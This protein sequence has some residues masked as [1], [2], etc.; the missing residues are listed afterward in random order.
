MKKF[1][2]NLLMLLVLA[3]QIATATTAQAGG[4]RY[5]TRV[6]FGGGTVGPKITSAPP[7]LAVGTP[8]TYRPTIVGGMSPYICSA[9]TLPTGLMFSVSTCTVAGTP[10]VASPFNITVADKS[11]ASTA[12]ALG[13]PVAPQYPQFAV[14]SKIA[15]LGDSLSAAGVEGAAPG[16]Q[17]ARTTN[18]GGLELALLMNPVALAEQWPADTSTEDSGYIAEYTHGANRAVGGT[19]ATFHAARLSTVLA[20]Q[21]AILY[22]SATVNSLT[23]SDVEN[24][25]IASILTPA[26]NAG[27][28]LAVGGIRPFAQGST[29]DQGATSI[30]ARIRINNALKAWVT[31]Q[32]PS[33]AI[34]VDH[35][36]YAD[37]D[38]DGYGDASLYWDGTHWNGLGSSMEGNYL[39]WTIFPQIF[40]SGNRLNA[41]WAAANY[42]SNP[43]LTGTGGTRSGNVTYAS[44]LSVPN[45]W[46]VGPSGTMTS[47]A[48]AGLEANA[49]T[50][51]QNIVLTVTP[52]A[53]PTGVVT[54]S[55]SG[56][57]LSVTATTSGA[58]AVGQKVT[59]AS[60]AADTYITAGAGSAFTVN[61]SQ[62]VASTSVS[63]YPTR[64]AIQITPNSAGTT[65]FVATTAL[66][67][68]YVAAFAEIEFDGNG[69]WIAPQLILSDNST[70]AN[71][72]SGQSYVTETF[73]RF[74]YDPT[75]RRMYV[76][77]NALLMGASSDGFRYNLTV[78]F[79]P[80]ILSAG[81]VA[82]V[83]RTW[84]G[85]VGNPIP[86]WGNQP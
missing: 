31:A 16:T 30:A 38:H 22:Y 72:R 63:G 32:G 1:L 25:I 70:T 66:Q 51:G 17:V 35:D 3:A 27:V 68:Q 71:G 40:A 10:T 73:G 15:V 82:K 28:Y 21:P 58:L 86:R 45:N 23:A 26:K 29:F 52:N 55:I 79:N 78:S 19:P 61:K 49:E 47:T 18:N 37:P 77:A 48:T 60:V 12:Q 74:Y 34:W 59:G 50:G 44:T 53:A 2:A 62:T 54:A 69:G 57:A 80:S 43:T 84:S 67:G 9:S 83:R 14:G 6:A 42:V 5:L 24:Y 33:V 56:T 81:A 76:Y 41:T 4:S 65:G 13:P 11:G 39:A 75:R 36:A 85:V 46:R 8:I 7:A 20:M 64:E